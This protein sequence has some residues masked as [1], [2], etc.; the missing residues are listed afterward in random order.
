VNDDAFLTELRHQLLSAAVATDTGTDT[1]GADET[2]APVGDLADRRGSRRRSSGRWFA[3]AAVVVAVVAGGIGFAG[4]GTRDVA[5][6]VEAIIRD[7]WVQVRLID[8]ESRPEEIEEAARSVGLDLDVVEV[9]VGP[10]QVGKFVS[11]SS[12]GAP[13]DFRRVGVDG[14]TYTGFRVPVGFD[15]SFTVNVGRVA[16]PGE[17]WATTSPGSAA[18]GDRCDDLIGETVAAAAD[19]VG[20]APSR[21]FAAAPGEPAGEFEPDDAT[22]ADWVVFSV[23]APSD[24][25]VWVQVSP[26]G[27]SPFPDGYP[28]EE[29]SC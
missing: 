3:A 18:I 19:I 9:P 11:M 15:G 7:G 13:P 16:R 21:W 25:E 20:D 8:V 12:D 5:A 2:P 26:D 24:D 23:V 10:G 27:A 14:S 17:Q 1:D 6:E 29:A 4:T 22:Y 28:I